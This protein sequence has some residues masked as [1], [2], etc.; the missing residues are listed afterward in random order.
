MLERDHD[1]LVVR[2]VQRGVIDPPEVA[3]SGGKGLHKAVSA[4][5]R[6]K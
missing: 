5:A 6:S 3:A 4:G 2:A 1:L